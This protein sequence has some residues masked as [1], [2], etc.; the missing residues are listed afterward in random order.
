M[1]TAFYPTEYTKIEDNAKNRQNYRTAGESC[2]IAEA[3]LLPFESVERL[4][5][6]NGAADMPDT[7]LVQS[8]DATKTASEKTSEMCSQKFGRYIAEANGARGETPDL[9]AEKPQQRICKRMAVQY[10]I[11]RHTQSQGFTTGN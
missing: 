11:F 6:G 4:M 9:G 2:A 3:L 1:L 7:L 10:A 5:E 8:I